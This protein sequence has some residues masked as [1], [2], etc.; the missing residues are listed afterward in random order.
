MVLTVLNSPLRA[1][2]SGPRDLDLVHSKG[3]LQ[4]AV[5]KVKVLGT[6]LMISQWRGKD[7]EKHVE[8]MRHM[9]MIRRVSQTF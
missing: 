1:H 7:S 2:W 4:M 6:R 3:S 5:H 9:Y 8:S